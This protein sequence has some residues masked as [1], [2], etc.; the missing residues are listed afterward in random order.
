VYFGRYEPYTERCSQ[1]KKRTKLNIEAD[2]IET[3]RL[4]LIPSSEKDTKFIFELLNSPKWIEY[5]GDRN[6]KTLNDAKQYLIEKIIPQYKKKG[7]GTFTVIRKFDN[8]KI[9]TCGLY[10]REDLE[11]VDLGFAFLP[12]FERNGYAFESANKIVNIAFEK[13]NLKSIKAI[14]T[15]NNISSQ[16]LLEKLKFI[17]NG[18]TKF[19]NEEMLQYLKT[20][21][22]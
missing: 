6:I 8:S 3:K 14:T 12:E 7:F 22:I 1:L 16:K 9:G 15:K 13:F 20:N 4:L 21:K 19:D 2:K 18:T 5:I 10:D 11:G 17:K